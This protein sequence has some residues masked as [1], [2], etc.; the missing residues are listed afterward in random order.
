MKS[1]YGSKG[2]KQSNSMAPSVAEHKYIAK[3]P[4]AKRGDDRTQASGNRGVQKPKGR[5]SGY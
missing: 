4:K 2:G 5:M 1:E 3:N